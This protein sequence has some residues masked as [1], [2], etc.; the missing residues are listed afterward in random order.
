MV[1]GSN[2]IFTVVTSSTSCSGI[3]ETY[4]RPLVQKPSSFSEMEMRQRTV[5]WVTCCQ[6]E[7]TLE[8]ARRDYQNYL[9]KRDSF[10]IFFLYWSEIYWNTDS[11]TILVLD[12]FA[13]TP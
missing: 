3:L 5:R 13:I 1:N 4:G 6:D 11:A 8:V 7:T 12:I 9:G 10:R 2:L